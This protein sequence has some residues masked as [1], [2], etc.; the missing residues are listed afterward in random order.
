MS[1]VGSTKFRCKRKFFLEA[2]LTTRQVKTW[3]LSIKHF[4]CF[5]FR[6]LV[7]T[8]KWYYYTTT[9]T[10][11]IVYIWFCVSGAESVCPSLPSSKQRLGPEL[12]RII[13]DG[14]WP[15]LHHSFKSSFLISLFSLFVSPALMLLCQQTA[16]KYKWPINLLHTLNI[17]AWKTGLPCVYFIWN[18]NAIIYKYLKVGTLQ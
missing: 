12:V 15:H 17:S 11:S 3:F 18:Y 16:A 7:V 9:K 8:L 6:N 4:I 5:I 14:Q 2:F 13:H 1:A 10:R